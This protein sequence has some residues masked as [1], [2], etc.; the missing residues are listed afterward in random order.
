MDKKDNEFKF[1]FSAPTKNEREEIED[2]RKNYLPMSSRNK[3]LARLKDLDAKVKNIPTIWGLVLGVTGI[4]TFGL[5][6]TITLEWSKFI[7]GACI[8]LIGAVPMALAYPVYKK[9]KDKL[10]NK[11]REEILKLSEELLNEEK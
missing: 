11:Y 7:F 1:S 8:S 6:L 10:T 9:S 5:G 4:L 3:K 2:I